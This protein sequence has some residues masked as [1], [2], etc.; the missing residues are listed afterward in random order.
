MRFEYRNQLPGKAPRG[1]RVD[2][3]LGTVIGIL[4]GVGLLVLLGIL[5]PFLIAGILG[6]IALIILLLVVGWVYLGFKIGWGGLWDLTRL[7]FSVFFGSG[8]WHTRAERIS[9][10]WE[11]RVKGKN[12][13]WV[14]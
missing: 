5:L 13:V 12:G 2:G 10:E 4:I 6:F 8:S 11:N 3:W 1:F 7:I 9:K 14:K